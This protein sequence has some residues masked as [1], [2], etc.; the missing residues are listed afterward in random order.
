M[1]NSNSAAESLPH[2]VKN[3]VK[4]DFIAAGNS[5]SSTSVSEFF[6]THPPPD[7]LQVCRDRVQRFVENLPAHGKIV[8]VTSGGT[9]VPLERNTVRF[10]DNFSTG[11]RGAAS[12]ERFLAAGYHVVFLTRRGSVQ[13]FLRHF[14]NITS[15][16]DL[17]LDCLHAAS[18]ESASDALTFK[19]P[20]EKLALLHNVMSARSKAHK[21]GRYLR[22]PFTSVEEYIYMLRMIS[23]VLAGAGPRAMLYVRFS[24]FVSFVFCWVMRI[25]IFSCVFKQMRKNL[26]SFARYFAAAVSDFYIPFTEMA[27]HKMQSSEGPPTIRLWGVPK[28]LRVLREQWCPKAFTV[29]FKLETDKTILIP[30]VCG[31]CTLQIS[32]G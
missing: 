7:N 13:P 25:Q 9:T 31:F 12:A 1:S 18:D 8:C 21:E 23:E 20:Q 14:I 29:S 17:F 3:G 19:P 28:C 32:T 10:I 6:A 24:F 27:T 30:K 2:S 22:L 11:T 4:G 16:P 15:N 5:T 26:D